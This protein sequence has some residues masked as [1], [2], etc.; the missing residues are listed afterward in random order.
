VKSPCSAATPEPT[1]TFC[2]VLFNPVSG[3]IQRTQAILSPCKPLVSGF[4]VPIQRF[5]RVLLNAVP[6][7]ETESETRLRRGKALVRG[8]P[9]PVCCL[10]GIDFDA[11][12]RPI[13]VCKGVLRVDVSS[14]RVSTRVSESL[15]LFVYFRLKVL[16]ELSFV[17]NFLEI[18]RKH[19]GEASSRDLIRGIRFEV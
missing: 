16:R 18:R 3:Q 7:L 5:F 14:L 13:A 6:G 8:F 17:R 9:K 2:L 12:S 10:H 1:Q 4:P 11:S 15:I 19:C